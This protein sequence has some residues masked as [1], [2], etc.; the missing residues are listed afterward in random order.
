MSS[1]SLD[2][3]PDTSVSSSR[4]LTPIEAKKLSILKQRLATQINSY[5]NKF[6]EGKY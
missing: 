3:T 4:R 5:P 1:S 2:K 6:P